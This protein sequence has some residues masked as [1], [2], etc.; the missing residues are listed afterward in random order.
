M[1]HVPPWL[2]HAI[3][4]LNTRMMRRTRLSLSDKQHTLVLSGITLPEVDAIKSV[5]RPGD[6]LNRVFTMAKQA[7]ETFKAN[8]DG[9]EPITYK[10][11][12]YASSQLHIWPRGPK[13][14]YSGR[15]AHP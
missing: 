6:D 3:L 7:R 12:Q 13:T 2:H 10:I 4:L 15:D 14:A 1:S 11:G 8:N 5:C 9:Q